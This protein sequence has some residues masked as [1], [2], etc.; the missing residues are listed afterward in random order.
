MFWRSVPG[1][2]MIEPPS[3]PVDTWIVEIFFR[4]VISFG[5]GALISMAEAKK[6]ATSSPAFERPRMMNRQPE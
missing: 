4:E 2:L 5:K 6:G 3:L 1:K